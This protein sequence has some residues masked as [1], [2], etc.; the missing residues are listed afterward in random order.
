MI[1]DQNGNPLLSRRQRQ[2]RMAGVGIEAYY[3][4]AQTNID[5]TRLWENA[6]L[7]SP[8]HVYRREVRWKL[9]SRSRFTFRNNSYCQGIALT[10]AHDTIGTGPVIQIDAQN[11][12]AADQLEQEFMAWAHEVDLNNKLMQYR[13]RKVIDGESFA[14]QEYNPKL[15]APV[16]L[17]WQ[18]YD[19]EQ[20]WS[21]HEFNYW[22][23]D[24]TYKNVPPVDGIVFDR[25]GNPETYYRVHVDARSPVSFLNRYQEP[26]AIRANFV[27]HY[28]DKHHSHQ[29]RG[30][31]EITPALGM[32]EELRR[33]T[34]AVIAAAETAADMAVVLA[35]NSPYGGFAQ[36]INSGGSEETEAAFEQVE[37]PRRMMMVAPEGWE[38]RQIKAEQPTNTHEQFVRQILRE[39]SRCLSMPYNVAAGDSS[40]YNYASG[41]LDHQV[42]HRQRAIDRKRIERDLDRLWNE[43]WLERQ[44][45]DMPLPD[46]G[47]INGWR[48]TWDEPEHVDP[49]KEAQAFAIYKEAGLLDIDEFWMRKKTSSR[50]V[51]ARMKRYKDLEEEFGLNQPDE[52]DSGDITTNPRLP[53]NRGDQNEA[54]NTNRV[55]PR[56]RES[57]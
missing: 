33:Y 2:D 48:W 4:N 7:Y 10:L 45:A 22:A 1:V 51:L 46:S 11:E 52:D 21:E 5:N 19:A 31:P 54:V 17:N 32:F 36:P 39:I 13:L 34:K 20:I 3:E 18:L 41:R 25:Y 26:D 27:H 28:F 35:T 24:P 42:Y 50:E 9:I 6:N 55:S 40:E 16:K 14:F 30:I 12:N 38:P 57:N 8:Y 43:W 47:R 23:W 56:T 44:A 15:E 53:G 37:I 49:L 29:M